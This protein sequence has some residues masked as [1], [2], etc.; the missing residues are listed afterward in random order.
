M[1]FLAPMLLLVLVVAAVAIWWWSR[2]PFIV[3]GGS[4]ATAVII[5]PDRGSQVAALALL[6]LGA[7]GCIA[8]WRGRIPRR[9]SGFV[10][11]LGVLAFALATHRLVVD[12][13][14]GEIRDIWALMTLQRLAM[15]PQDGLGLDPLW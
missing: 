14:R 3:V 13:G 12:G 1:K 5:E 9:V 7:A 2:D 4:D 11:A 15:S 10:L 8:L 6:V